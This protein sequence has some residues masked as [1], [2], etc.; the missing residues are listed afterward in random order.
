[1]NVCDSPWICWITIF[2]KGARKVLESSTSGSD[3][4]FWLTT[5]GLEI[6]L[7]S[8]PK[9]GSLKKWFW[10]S[11]LIALWHMGSSQVRDQTRAS[12]MGRQILH[13]WATREVPCIFMWNLRE[14]L[15][16][17]FPVVIIWSFSGQEKQYT[18]LP[19]SLTSTFWILWSRD[20][21]SFSRFLK[22]GYLDSIF[23]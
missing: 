5:I 14:E 21:S 17:G 2:L 15:T 19:P 22:S 23:F 20:F 18:F 10:C 4:H 9:K 8:R 6:L 12:C 7:E 1:M 13:H 11:G 3:S 16:F